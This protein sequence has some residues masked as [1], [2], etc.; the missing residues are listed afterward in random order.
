MGSTNGSD[1][2]IFIG[3][4]LVATSKE[5]SSE[6][7]P[8]ADVVRE[9]N[10]EEGKDYDNIDWGIVYDPFR[11]Y[12]VRNGKMY[13]RNSQAKIMLEA[14]DH[15]EL[16]NELKESG[17]KSGYKHGSLFNINLH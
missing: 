8:A 11:L 12:L 9:L 1:L 14:S 15:A 10:I 3:D 7:P 2:N 5:F 16:Y 4:T 13:F 17:L 6:K